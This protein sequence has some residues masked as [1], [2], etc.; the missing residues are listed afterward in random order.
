MKRIWN[1]L[2]DTWQ[3]ADGKLS[4][5]RILVI[6]LTIEV[7]RMIERNKITSDQT[8]SAFYAILGTILVT[9][10]IVTFAQ[11]KS[12]DI[13]PSFSKTTTSETKVITPDM[14]SVVNEVKKEITP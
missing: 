5:K 12:I 14:S 1:Y 13:V 10:G 3:G 11:L 6:T 4:L 8:L 9:L 7:V 2:A